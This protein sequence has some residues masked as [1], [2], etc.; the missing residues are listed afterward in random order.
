M[1]W[2]MNQLSNP[3]N[4]L[5]LN[6]INHMLSPYVFLNSIQSNLNLKNNILKAYPF[7]SVKHLQ[8]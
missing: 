4:R 5:S 3:V 1:L 8:K 6:L 7:I 2:G